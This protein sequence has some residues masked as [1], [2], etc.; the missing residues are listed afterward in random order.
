MA[1]PLNRFVLKYLKQLEMTGVIMRISSFSVVSWM[2]ADSPFMYVWLLNTIDAILLT[3][4]AILKKDAAYSL[5]N[6]FWILV[7]LVGVLRA[8]DFIH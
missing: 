1:D 4:C 6:G 3:W 5:L 2:G 8:G 7:G